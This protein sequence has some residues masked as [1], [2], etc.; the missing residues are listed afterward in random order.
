MAWLGSL[1]AGAYQLP[2]GQREAAPEPFV[3]SGGGRRSLE[4]IALDRRMAAGQMA[5]GADFS[6]V[7]HWTQGLARATQGILGGLE[8][9]ELRD[10]AAEVKAAQDARNASIAQLLIGGGGGK[11]IVAQALVDPSLSPEVRGLAE[12]QFKRM[13]PTPPQPSEFERALEFSGI[14]RGTPEWSERMQQRV[15]NMLDPVVNVPLPGGGVFLGPRSELQSVLGGG[16]P[17]SSVPGGAMPPSTLPPDF[18]FDEGG[19][20][21]SASGGFR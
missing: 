19:P 20:T 10:E 11:D 2:I 9:G 3:W 1:P 4:D 6:P 21:P 13:N 15:T 17:A 12:M 7:G 8:M 14:Q 16:D 5:A 18:D